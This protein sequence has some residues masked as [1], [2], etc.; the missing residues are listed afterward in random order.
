MKRI[1]RASTKKRAPSSSS[2]KAPRKE[3]L[4]FLE[5]LKSTE[6]PAAALHLLLHAPPHL[7][8]YPVCASLLHRL[9]RARLFPLVDALLLFVRSNSVPCKDP[10][11][12]SLIDHFGKARLPHRALHLFLSIPSFNCPPSAPTRQT[13]NFLL[14][15]LVDNDALHE[16]ESSLARCKEWNLRPNVVSYNIIIKGRCEKHGFESARHLFDEMRKRKVRPSVVSYNIL[17]GHMSRNGHLGGAIRMKEEMVSKGTHPNAVT[18]ALLM[19]GLCREGKFDSAKKMMFDMQYQGCKTRLVNYGVLMSDCGRRGDLDGMK[20]LFVEMTRRRLRPDAVSYNILINYLCARGGVDD[21]YKVF[22][23]MQMKGC[24]PIAA[25]YRMMVDGFCRAGRALVVGLC[26]GG[27]LD[28]ACFV[29]E[30][31]EKRKMGLGFEG[32]SSLVEAC[33]G[34][35]GKVF[36][37]PIE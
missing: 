30:A 11:F 3:R 24:E 8:D 26:E 22:V 9:A 18:Y 1:S 32:W 12:N 15:A 35:T 19:E 10:I 2:P 31:M 14:N 20:K 36:E 28:D 17:I 13:L 34:D 27:K 6:N 16:A 33:C 37:L 21:A 5:E 4:P 7:Q 25:T 23:E 29:L